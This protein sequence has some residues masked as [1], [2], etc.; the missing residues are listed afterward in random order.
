MTD[1][2]NST[3][4]SINWKQLNDDQ[5]KLIK[6]KTWLLRSIGL[7]FPSIYLLWSRSYILFIIILIVEFLRA[8]QQYSRVTRIETSLL[9]IMV[10]VRLLI[11]IK[12]SERAFDNSL[13]YLKNLFLDKPFK[14]LKHLY[15]RK[16]Q[17]QLLVCAV[18]LFI[19]L[20]PIIEIL[21]WN[22]LVHDYCLSVGAKIIGIGY[23]LFAVFSWVVFSLNKK[24]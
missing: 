3:P 16:F 22:K 19:A 11:F 10:I 12:G 1:N 2:H 8:S 20:Q 4:S 14:Y 6:E 17:A 18:L 13:W 21:F 7:I 23:L 5:K 15:H 9:I 24:S